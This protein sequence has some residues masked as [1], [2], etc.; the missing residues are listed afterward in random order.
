MVRTTDRGA[1]SIGFC[2]IWIHLDKQVL[3][4]CNLSV[5]CLYLVLDKS[6]KFIGNQTVDAIHQILFWSF[7]NLGFVHEEVK[8]LRIALQELQNV[9][10]GESFVCRHTQVLNQVTLELLLL[11]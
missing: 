1:S 8:Y 9:I 7:W 3:F 10:C 11:A 5:P 6:S 2:N 4:D